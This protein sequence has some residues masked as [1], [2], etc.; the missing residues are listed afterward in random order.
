MPVT[1]YA[2]DFSDLEKCFET[3]FSTEIK[4]NQIKFC[5]VGDN[6]IHSSLY[7]QANS[8]ANGD[9]YDFDY[10]YENVAYFFEDYDINWI[11]QESIIT[12][13]EPSSYPLFSTPKEV[14][15]SLY[16]IGFRV[17]SVSNNHTYDKGA[18]G[19]D[20]SVE[21]L[22]SIEDIYY[23]GLYHDTPIEEDIKIQEVDGVDIAY[24]S[25]TEMTNGLPTPQNTSRRVIY[26]HETDLIESLILKAKE[27]ADIVIVGMHWGVENSFGI[28]Q[29]Q[30][31]V[32][33]L[34]AAAGVDVIIGTHSHV[35]GDLEWV[36]RP[37][38]GKMLVAYSLGN[39]ISAQAEPKQ[40]VGLALTYNIES[41]ELNGVILST[42]IKNVKVYPT[43][44]HYEGF[45]K[46]VRDYM[47]RDY[48]DELAKTHG[49]EMSME[50]IQNLLKDHVSEEFLV[51]N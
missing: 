3:A 48:S 4:V 51:L 2:K 11:N 43:V 36:E 45:Y 21:I 7:K 35:V 42:D 49:R 24:L 34:C 13:F 27:L 14:I 10:A 40:L 5:G 12:N 22:D 1:T 19:I 31:D 16:N 17:F 41:T 32:S 46:N 26:T 15:T 44:T 30:R 38:G 8:R 28:T 39:F 29:N 9:G 20:S 47:Y 37:D 25:F 18:M 33:N 50:Y 6:L 23:T